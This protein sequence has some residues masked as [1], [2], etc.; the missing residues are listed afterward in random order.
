MLK[1]GLSALAIAGLRVQAFLL[2]FGGTGVKSCRRLHGVTQ[3]SANV[4]E[5]RDFF[6]QFEGYVG[7]RWRAEQNIRL[8]PI[9][10]ARKL[11]L[12]HRCAV[13]AW[14]SLRQPGDERNQ[15]DVHK[16]GCASAHLERIW[17][18]LR[19]RASGMTDVFR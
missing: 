4:A 9:C 2:K 3:D 5:Q 13:S 12:V 10:S 17:R 15:R 1:D 18:W 19:G 6:F 16:R 7:V 8:I 14:F 11:H